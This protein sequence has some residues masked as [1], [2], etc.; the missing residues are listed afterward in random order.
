MLQVPLACAV[1]HHAC[2]NCSSNRQMGLAC[3]AIEALPR[4]LQ[5]LLLLL[6]L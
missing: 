6:L 4:S 2:L 5:A 1:L 3:A